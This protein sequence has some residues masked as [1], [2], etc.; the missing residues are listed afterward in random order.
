[1]MLPSPVGSG[2]LH[3]NWRRPAR[4]SG[5]GCI[6]PRN[7]GIEGDR[8]TLSE[9][10]MRNP[11]GFNSRFDGVPVLDFREQFGAP[12]VSIRGVNY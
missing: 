10:F 9:G 12:A 5:T 11:V 2:S 1:M 6:P 7:S 3:P 8:P 4:R